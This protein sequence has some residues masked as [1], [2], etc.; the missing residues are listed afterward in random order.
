MAKKWISLLLLIVTAVVVWGAALENNE[1]PVLTP[2]QRETIR[3]YQLDD[4]RFDSAIKQRQLE[5]G[6]LQTQRQDNAK[7][8]MDYVAGVCGQDFS[9]DF[10][11]DDL[12]CVAKPKPEVKK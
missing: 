6:Q 8:F 4:T 12:R 11:S 9:F 1:P 10:N 3:K 2:Q 7:R 5:I